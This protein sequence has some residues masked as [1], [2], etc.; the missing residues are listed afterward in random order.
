MKLVDFLVHES[1]SPFVYLNIRTAT[2][3]EGTGAEGPPPTHWTRSRSCNG[4]AL[5]RLGLRARTPYGT[6]ANRCEPPGAATLVGKSATPSSWTMR[7]PGFAQ[8]QG[9]GH[10]LPSRSGAPAHSPARL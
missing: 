1:G 5:S 9:R 2:W 4:S 8:V 10:P 3:G 6:E 7:G